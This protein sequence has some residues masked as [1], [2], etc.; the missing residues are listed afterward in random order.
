MVAIYRSA[1]NSCRPSH[2]GRGLK[3]FALWEVP[4]MSRVAPHM[5]AW[6]ETRSRAGLNTALTLSLARG[7]RVETPTI[8]AH[9]ISS[10]CLPPR[11]GG[12]YTRRSISRASSSSGWPTIVPTSLVPPAKTVPFSCAFL[13][14]FSKPSS[15]PM[16]CSGV[17]GS[18]DSAVVSR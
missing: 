17:W 5:K 13:N 15:S 9:A 14:T 16:A 8:G 2:E 11:I 4:A 18:V 10:A 1:I 12:R 3:L 6:T 7:M